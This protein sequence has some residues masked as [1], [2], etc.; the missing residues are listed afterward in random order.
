MNI[1]KRK[2]KNQNNERVEVKNK[3]NLE[4]IN[5]YYLQ[6]MGIFKKGKQAYSCKDYRNAIV[7]YCQYIEII[8]RV[9]GVE[10]KKMGPNLFDPKAELME[11]MMLSS[12]YWDLVKIYDQSPAL[13]K[14]FLRCLDQFCVFTLN[15]PHQDINIQIMKRFIRNGNPKNKKEFKKTYKSIYS[16]SK[17]CYIA[18]YC[19]GPQHFVTSI[20]RDFKGFL[21]NYKMGH[22]AVAS[23]YRYS[24]KMILFFNK[25]PKIG[26][27][28]TRFFLKPLLKLFALIWK[29]CSV[30]CRP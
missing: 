22:F 23:Y 28:I 11:V 17:K 18:D 24:P 13:K 8:S 26:F 16:S 25:H 15:F 6:R 9:K 3:K 21:L 29:T 12:I 5:R 10:E 19:F 30:D 7:Y 27:W 1:P 20:L 14:E 4:A 2:R